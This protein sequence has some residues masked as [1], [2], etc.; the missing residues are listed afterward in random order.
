M[1]ISSERLIELLKMTPYPIFR[2]K[3]TKGTDYPYVVY[4]LI[5]E[6]YKRSS[7]RIH[8]KLPLYQVSLFTEGLKN[9]FDQ[10]LMLLD[11]NGV[12]F[13]SLDSMQGDENSEIVTHFFVKV[14]CHE[15]VR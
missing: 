14:R 11:D 8:K 9:D 2:D 15:N 3:A 13:S 12:P 7:S 1:S 10:I 4:S 6:P 5:S